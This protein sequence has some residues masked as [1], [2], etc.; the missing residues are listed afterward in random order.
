MI[1]AFP[2]RFRNHILRTLSLLLLTLTG[3]SPACSLRQPRLR[4]ESR[5][6]LP[7]CV[8]IQTGSPN[9]DPNLEAYK[10]AFSAVAVYCRTESATVLDTLGLSGSHLILVIP[11][12]TARALSPSQIDNVLHLVENG[13][14][15]VSEGITPLSERMGFRG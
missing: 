1:N 12:K 14:T 5:L 15:L 10:S 2:I 11:M 7:E 6:Y 8:V 9:G 13:A 4:A 3:A